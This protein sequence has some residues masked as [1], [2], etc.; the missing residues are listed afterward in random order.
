MTPLKPLEAMA[1]RRLVAASDVGGHL[2]LIEDD[3]TGTIFPAGNPQ[4]LADAVIELFAQR[5]SWDAR[6]TTARDFVEKHR[7]WSF[8][9]SRYAP[10]YHKLTGLPV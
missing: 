8:N 1:Q 10:V 7:N 2:E 5:E 3:S 4:A 6:R 9:I